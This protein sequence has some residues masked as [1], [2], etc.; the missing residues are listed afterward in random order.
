MTYYPEGSLEGIVSAYLA[1]ADVSEIDI[2]LTKDFIPV[3]YHDE[4]LATNTDWEMK[5]GKNGLPESKFIQD[6]TFAELKQLRFVKNGVV[7]DY[8]IPSF[9][10]A[11][12]FAG[13][14]FMLSIDD[15]TQVN[16]D[17]DEDL[18]PIGRDANGLEALYR[19]AGEQK[20][21]EWMDRP[22]VSA[23]YIENTKFF[24]ACTK[25][26]TYSISGASA[27]Y[28]S[29]FFNDP[30]FN[31]DYESQAETPDNAWKKLIAQGKR[32]IGTNMIV[33]MCNYF[34]SVYK[35]S[36]YSRIKY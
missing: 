13:G 36:D 9:Y 26:N 6:W 28:N 1:G 15:K 21:K 18:F 4:S 16:L 2:R 19:S 17:V 22:G 32:C 7:T 35:P 23:R 8:R 29:S 33:A 34:D 27:Y 31:G 12:A 24:L 14:K 11:L 10:E 25:T 20:A 3:S 5:A 30:P